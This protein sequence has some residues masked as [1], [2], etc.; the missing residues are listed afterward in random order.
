MGLASFWTNFSRRETSARRCS[1]SI[2]KAGVES[3][4]MGVGVTA[5]ISWSGCACRDN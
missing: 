5:E 4:I 2:A 1:T 3:A